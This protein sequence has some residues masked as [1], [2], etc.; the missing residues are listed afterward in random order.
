MVNIL[1][2]SH[3]RKLVEGL[4]DILKQMTSDVNIVISGG[5]KEGNIGSNFDE[6]YKLMNE[7]IHDD[8]LVVFFDLGSSMLNCQM[9]L[10][11]LDE[12]K[13]EKVYLAGTPLVETSV[14]VAVNASAGQTLEEIKSYLESYP[15][16]KI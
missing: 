3:S 1:L 12:A 15:K 2:T 8:G 7:N 14:Q 13:K 6:I 11:M 4:K 16:S 5:D 10:D 9:A